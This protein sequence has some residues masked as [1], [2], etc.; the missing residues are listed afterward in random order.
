MAIGLKRPSDEVILGQPRD[1]NTRFELLPPPDP[2]GPRFI[3]RVKPFVS[4]GL[5]SVLWV[6]GM[7]SIQGSPGPDCW[8][9]ITR[10]KSFGQGAQIS[11]PGRSRPNTARL[12]IDFLTAD[13]A[14]D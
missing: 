10:F 5:T 6:G 9:S 1:G 3:A 2:A 11:F 8:W 4:L 14:V 7:S 13:A 12:A